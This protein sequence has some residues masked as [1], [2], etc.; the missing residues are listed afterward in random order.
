MCRACKDRAV[1]GDG[2]LGDALDIAA[3][4]RERSPRSS[5][6]FEARAGRA[7]WKPSLQSS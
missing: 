2:Q 4:F 5:Q 1:V 3:R 7:A 6:S